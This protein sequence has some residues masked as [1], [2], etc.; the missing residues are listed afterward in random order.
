MPFTFSARCSGPDASNQSLEDF[1]AAWNRIREVYPFFELK[2]IDWDS[3]HAEY[4]PRAESAEGTE[5]HAVLHDLLA[6]LKDGHVYYKT[7]LDDGVMPYHPP[8]R[9]RDLDAFSLPLV[10]TYFDT[11]LEE[12][13]E[14]S[15]T[16]GI[17]PNDVGYVYFATYFKRLP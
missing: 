9:I 4:R 7:D 11:E 13:S 16:Y 17:L 15:A 2:E 14:G 5:F 6:E 12:T 10:K 3:L 1:E 8:R